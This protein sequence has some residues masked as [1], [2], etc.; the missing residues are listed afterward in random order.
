MRSAQANGCERA[1]GRSV[2]FQH[3]RP[4][5]LVVRIEVARCEGDDA[6][7]RVGDQKLVTPILRM[8]VSVDPGR[9][10]TDGDAQ[11]VKKGQEGVDIT[12]AN[13]AGR[14]ATVRELLRMTF[15]E[16]APDEVLRGVRRLQIV[17]RM[18]AGL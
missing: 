11:T 14:V 10:R 7:V 3:R 18:D 17:C 16:T 5:V 8:L 9:N 6:T 2:P 12:E 4:A 13:L 1:I 15:R